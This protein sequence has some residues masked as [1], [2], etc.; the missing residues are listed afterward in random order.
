MQRPQ[1][2]RVLFKGRVR[3]K[4]QNTEVSVSCADRTRPENEAACGAAV[5]AREP[6]VQL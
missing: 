6:A 3:I 1:C 5:S 2:Y 4:A